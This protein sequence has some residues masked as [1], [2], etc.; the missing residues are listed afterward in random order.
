M[1]NFIVIGDDESWLK[2]GQGIVY[3]SRFPEYTTQET[4]SKLPNDN[5][6]ILDHIKKLPTL[7]TYEGDNSKIF[8]TYIDE[9]KDQDKWRLALHFNV[10][11]QLSFDFADIVENIGKFDIKDFEKYRQHWS[12][13][14]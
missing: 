10:T 7:F 14:S 4:L 3:K 9:I 1:F 11:D 6:S 8:L 13:K 12:I 5:S 2:S